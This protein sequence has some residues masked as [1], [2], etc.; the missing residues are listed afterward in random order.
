MK[1]AILDTYVPDNEHMPY[2][3]AKHY[4]RIKVVS[5][6][7]LPSNRRVKKPYN[8]HGSHSTY[9]ATR[10]LWDVEVHCIECLDN[11]GKGSFAEIV[12]GME[13]AKD[14]NSDVDNASFGFPRVNSDDLNVLTYLSNART[15]ANAVLCAAGGNEGYDPATGE[16]VADTVCYPAKLD[17]W[18][19]T[20]SGEKDGRSYYSAIGDEILFVM[21]GTRE[22]S[23]GIYGKEEVSGTSEACPMLTGVCARLIMESNKLPHPITNR[24]IWL[25]GMLPFFAQHDWRTETI[26]KW[27]MLQ[28]NELTGFGS[29]KKLYDKMCTDYDRYA[30]DITDVNGTITTGGL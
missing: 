10:P 21:D 13:L 29:L 15:R 2:E 26:N 8:P 3:M 30:S 24:H 16:P 5:H 19:A 6:S 11:E 23:V 18:F 9:F 17:S 14:I 28:R 20:G 25:S 12:R 27:E 1:I 7:V 4:E 22:I